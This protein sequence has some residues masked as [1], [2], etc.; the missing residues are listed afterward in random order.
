[1]DTNIR[2]QWF[3]AVLAEYSSLRT[4]SLASMQHQQSTLSLGT[5]AIGVLLGF[6][7][8]ASSPA[9]LVLLIAVV[10]IFATAIY[11]LY[12][13]EFSRMVRVGRYLD[14]LEKHVNSVFA[15]QHLPLG[16]EG[17]LNGKGAQA[18]SPQS[19]A[20]WPFKKREP[21]PRLPFYWAVPLIVAL[22][23]SG[24]II[25]GLTVTPPEAKWI[26]PK[27]LL[28]GIFGAASLITIVL[29]SVQLQNSRSRYDVFF[30]R[31]EWRDTPHP[32]P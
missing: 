8:T 6:G 20:S 17:W 18:E 7:L 24:S 12:A 30:E 19:D 28:A 23:A 14:D 25:I 22:V 4:E 2:E 16:W 26:L 9:S 21:T 5:A 15:G 32:P 13:I 10:P 29:V 31:K 1:M 11:L 3:T 27:L